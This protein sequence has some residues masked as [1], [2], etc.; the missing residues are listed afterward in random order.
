MSANHHLAR[1]L[2]DLRDRMGVGPADLT[3]DEIADLVHACDRAENPFREVNADAAGIPVRVCEG[4]HFWK[5]T[6]GAS[7]WLDD[8]ARL[9]EG[10]SDRYR[11]CLIHALV[12]AREPDAFDGLE[13]ER[14]I[15]KAVKSTCR[16]IAATPEEVDHALD[17]V[18]GLA[19]RRTVGKTD[20]EKAAM[21]WRS[22]CARLETQT[23]IPAREWIWSRSSAYALHCYN[24]LDAFARACGGKSGT[25]MRD[26]LDAAT[27]ALQLVKVRIMKRVERTRGGA[28]G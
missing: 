21:D 25:T 16:R 12:H 1:A 15:L 8:I 6:I 9:F 18:L 17:E 19:S 26:E 3:T 11:L 5:L 23:G 14:S 20:V 10:R 27:E 13:D 2:A 7:I 28:N 4:V 24:D 22:L